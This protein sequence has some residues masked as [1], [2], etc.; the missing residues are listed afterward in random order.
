[1]QRFFDQLIQFVQQG[2]GFIFRFV[3][4]VWIWSVGQITS[5]FL[6]PWSEW[7]V[8]K[9]ILLLIIVG[10]VGYTLIWVYRDLWAAAQTILGAFGTLLN[11]LIRTL[12][13]VLIAGLIALG[14]VWVLNNVD[15]SRIR[16]PEYRG[17]NANGR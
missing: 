8:Q 7:P 11:V 2:I 10:A 12:P 9:Q 14:G 13:R 4:F 17:D 5:L 6:V 16:L 15:F 3:Q 1:M